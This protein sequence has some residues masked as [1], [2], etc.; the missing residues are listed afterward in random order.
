[1]YHLIF[2][3]VKENTN[4]IIIL[5]VDTNTEASALLEKQ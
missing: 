3:N 4:I 2:R 5:T 1:M